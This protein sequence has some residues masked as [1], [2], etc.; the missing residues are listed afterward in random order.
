MHYVVVTYR[1]E[2]LQQIRRLF[3]LLHQ[4]KMPRQVLQGELKEVERRL[5]YQAS[6]TSQK[7]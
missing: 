5:D 4:Q 7:K 2:V 6:T 1:S 3:R